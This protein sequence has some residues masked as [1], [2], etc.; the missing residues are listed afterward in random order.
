MLDWIPD[1]LDLWH[2]ATGYYKNKKSLTLAPSDHILGEKIQ[3][4]Q[5]HPKIPQ[6]P[7]LVHQGDVPVH[8][9]G[10]PTPASMYQ[11]VPVRLPNNDPSTT[12]VVHNVE[13]PTFTAQGEVRDNVLH[14]FQ[15]LGYT[16]T[17]HPV[18]FME[19]LVDYLKRGA[20][21]VVW[22]YQDFFQQL[23][24]WDGSWLGFTR[25]TGLMWRGMMV[26]LITVGIV[27]VAPLLQSLGTWM[28]LVFDFVRGF[29]GLVG[30]A[31]DELWYLLQTIVEDVR[32]YLGL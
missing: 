16:M 29:L 19:L 13:G 3:L 5:T 32:Y 23:Q 4:R 9:V 31:V 12:S 25:L 8:L 20:G 11:P 28:R 21:W 10:T 22:N 15:H 6:F 27:E 1:P 30:S 2:H 24:Q 7:L 14:P 17:H 18:E 26:A